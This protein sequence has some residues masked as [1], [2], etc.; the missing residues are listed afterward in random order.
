MFKTKSW[1][2]WISLIVILAVVIS[3]PN[4][5][6]NLPDSQS[7]K[8]DTDSVSSDTSVPGQSGADVVPMTGITVPGTYVSGSN[9]ATVSESKDVSISDIDFMRKYVIILNRGEDI[10]DLSGWKLVD[11][12]V[13][14]SFV[15]PKEAKI[16]PGGMLQ[17]L[18]GS[19]EKATKFR[20][21]WNN[22]DVWQ[23]SN[24]HGACMIKRAVW[25]RG[26]E[27]RESTMIRFLCTGGT[28]EDL[29]TTLRMAPGLPHLH[30][31]CCAKTPLLSVSEP[32]A[33]R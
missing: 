30:P 22:K 2:L 16:L 26:N 23:D 28:G 5:Y 17:V 20:L 21:R 13:N 19:N 15:F 27:R 3:W 4:P 11:E 12:S 9:P 18:S 7:G 8:T 31:W 33:P 29:R 25:C 6:S 32:L 14:Q 1:I 10:V 24:G